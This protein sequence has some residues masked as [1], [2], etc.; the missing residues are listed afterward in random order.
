MKKLWYCVA[1]LIVLTGCKSN[2]FTHDID[3]GPTPWT[4]KKFLDDPE[5]FH[6]A[7][8]SD[9]TGGMRPGVFAKAVKKVNLLRP[10]FV[11]C[12]GDLI[13]GYSKSPKQV[14]KEQDEF[15]AIVNRLDMPFFYLP[16]NHDIS[17][18][19]MAELWET[20]YGRR[21]YSFIYKDV[22]FICLD[23]LEHVQP[24]SHKRTNFSK[25]QVKW[26][27]K[28]LRKNRNVRWTFLFMHKPGWLYQ[29]GY[30]WLN[31]GVTPPADNGF[32]KIREALK[33]RDY[34]VFAGHFHLYTKYIRDGQKY[35]ILSVTGGG[36]DLSGAKRGA[37]DHTVWVTMTR[38]GPV[39]ANLAIDGI[40]NEDIV[41]EQDYADMVR[42]NVLK[43]QLKF[44]LDEAKCTT[45]EMLFTA[46]L[47]N[48]YKEEMQYNLEWL[49]TQAWKIT[50]NRLKGSLAPGKTGRFQIKA[51]EVNKKNKLIPKCKTTFKFKDKTE[52]PF[53]ISTD[54]LIR[55]FHRPVSSA[56]FAE[57]KPAIDGRLNDPVWKKAK[58]ISGFKKMHGGK[59]SVPTDTRIAYDRNNLYLAFTCHEPEIKK[60]TA[61]VKKHDGR[62]FSDDCIEIMLDTK[63]DRKN[64]YHYAVNS[65]GI[66]Y[67]ARRFNGKS[68]RKCELHAERAVEKNPNS[69]TLEIA[70]PWK[71]LETKAPGKDQKMGLLLFRCRK[72]DG[73]E[74]QQYPALY[75]GNHQPKMF[76]DLKF[77]K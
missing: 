45:N 30:T 48:P 77:E 13:R 36:S 43:R 19:M 69:W 7:I 76:G 60:I 63:K 8:M 24:G 27:V 34:T 57:V 50:P 46:V 26:V 10:E 38:K 40:H 4:K 65:A 68:N 25:T 35:F 41:V 17:N 6:F 32:K 18:Q 56:V 47:K 49:N 1:V 11:M 22:L 44:Y 66:D 67:D 61:K 73:T 52:G 72:V 29:E 16:G 33:G 51:V 62:V 20:R 2:P 71:N 21:Y 23:S 28:V 12:V 55:Q 5:E 54:K 37:F 74:F 64:Y 15:D 53:E 31:G 14:S 39:M 3:S 59:T 42:A 9:R 58:K 75:G 70:I